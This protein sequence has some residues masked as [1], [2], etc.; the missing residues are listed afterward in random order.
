MKEVLVQ[1]HDVRDRLPDADTDVLV[2]DRSSHEAQLGAL[3]G[4]GEWVDANG[5][6]IDG[7]THWAEMPRFNAEF[8]GIGRN[9]AT[10]DH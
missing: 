5:G 8:T 10:N 2:F 4:E 9:G 7:V 6:S 3:V 1:V